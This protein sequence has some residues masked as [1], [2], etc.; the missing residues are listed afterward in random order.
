MQWEGFNFGEVNKKAWE[1]GGV[2]SLPF[3]LVQPAQTGPRKWGLR[4][5]LRG[6]PRKDHWGLDQ[7]QETQMMGTRMTDK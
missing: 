3:S 5:G 2:L 7:S 4:L 1:A 6:C